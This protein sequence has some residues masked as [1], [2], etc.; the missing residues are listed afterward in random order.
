[1]TQI[2]RYGSNDLSFDSKAR[3]CLGALDQVVGGWCFV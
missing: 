1:M 2:N 3:E